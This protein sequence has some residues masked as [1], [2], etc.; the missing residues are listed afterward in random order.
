MANVVDN[1]RV[2]NKEVKKIFFNGK[3][4]KEL[5]APHQITGALTLIWKNAN[6][7]VFITKLSDI[8]LT[9][10]GENTLFF[11]GFSDKIFDG[12]YSLVENAEAEKPNLTTGQMVVES[13]MEG[14]E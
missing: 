9:N 10:Y 2:N 6:P 7:F 13:A 5:W 4:L 3:A 1:L 14:D 8:N 11:E 12:S